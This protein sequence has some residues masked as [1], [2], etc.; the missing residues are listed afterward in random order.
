MESI[1]DEETNLLI[2]RGAN[3]SILSMCASLLGQNDYEDYMSR[4]IPN[5]EVEKLRA[6]C[7]RSNKDCP[8][9]TTFDNIAIMSSGQGKLTIGKSFIV[10]IIYKQP[11][12]QSNKKE[13]V[14]GK[15]WLG[16]K[17]QTEATQKQIPNNYELGTLI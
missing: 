16:Q 3:N 8:C 12:T 2:V 15:F 17:R 7:R 4:T 1:C 5:Q 13:I 6:Y 14:F 11:I 9:K 10:Q